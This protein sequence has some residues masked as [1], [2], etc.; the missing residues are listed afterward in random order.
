MQVADLANVFPTETMEA[1]TVL[2]EQGGTD[3]DGFIVQFGKVELSRE[4][5]GS[6]QRGIFVG[7][8]EIL[9]VYKTLFENDARYFTGTVVEKSR[10]TRIPEQVLK[11]RI[12]ASDPFIIYCVRN[13]PNF[14]DRLIGWGT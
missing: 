6:V 11:D 2:F 5:G 12:A 9:G 4:L 8:G 3:G 13:W 10:I 14:G 1:V 7:A